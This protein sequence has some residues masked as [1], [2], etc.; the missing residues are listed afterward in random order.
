MALQIRAGFPQLLIDGGALANSSDCCCDDPDCSNC[1]VRDE[2]P[3]DCYDADFTPGTCPSIRADISGSMGSFTCGSS[4]TDCPDISASFVASCDPTGGT[5]PGRCAYQKSWRKDFYL[6]S[7]PTI[8]PGINRANGLRVTV[9]ISN[10]GVSITHIAIFK[11]YADT[12]PVP[13]LECP[14]WTEG[15]LA[16]TG[17]T[18]LVDP[19]RPSYTRSQSFSDG[20]PIY[21]GYYYEISVDCPLDCN[22]LVDKNGCPT[23]FTP[24]INRPDTAEAL[25]LC[26]ANNLTISLSVV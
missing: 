11:N 8:N 26:T 9:S 24:A 25:G 6:C 19:G 2:P 5:A 14:T 13:D 12:D 3:C 10:Y 17:P 22:Y 15:T 18:W 23:A 16:C 21:Q 4:I 1:I 20:N 7:Q